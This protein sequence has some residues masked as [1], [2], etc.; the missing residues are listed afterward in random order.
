MQNV[1]KSVLHGVVAALVFGITWFVDSGNVVTTLTVGSVLT[2]VAHWLQAK[3][4]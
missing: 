2:M 4:L 1:S 3:F